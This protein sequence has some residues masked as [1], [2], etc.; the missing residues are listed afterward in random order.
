[1]Y[2]V[3]YT[4]LGYDAIYC[5]GMITYYM[6]SAALMEI[7]YLSLSRCHARVKSELAKVSSDLLSEL[8]ITSHSI[9]PSSVSSHVHVFVRN[10]NQYM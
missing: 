6:V 2:T 1:M 10:F 9:M 4:F 3:N 5:R 8:M 7:T